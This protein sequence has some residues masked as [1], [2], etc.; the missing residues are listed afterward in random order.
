MEKLGLQT[1]AVSFSSTMTRARS[2]E[3]VSQPVVPTTTGIPRAASFRYL[4]DRG[5]GR[6]ELDRH[7]DG[8]AA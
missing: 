1:S 4:L 7:I 2:I 8:P 3:F 5:L 6:G